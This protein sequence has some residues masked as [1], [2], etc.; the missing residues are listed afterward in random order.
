MKK[1]PFLSPADESRVLEA[2]RRNEAR[3]TGEIRICLGSSS[4]AEVQ[5]QARR[6]FE[7]LEMHRT[8]DRNGVLVYL[9]PADRTLAIVG[10][11]GIHEHCGD[12]F[13]E[14]IATALSADFARQDVVAG[15]E[16]ALEAIGTALARHYPRNDSDTNEL[17]DAIAS[18]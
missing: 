6:A 5:A 11:A 9:A 10:D 12:A 7:R 2:L 18:E 13:W 3:T 1:P 14:R 8:R 17:P 4:A 16:R 15:L